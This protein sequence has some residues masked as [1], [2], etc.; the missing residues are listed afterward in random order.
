[1]C[2][3]LLS[4]LVFLCLQSAVFQLKVTDRALNRLRWSDDGRCVVVGDASGTV[5]V[6]KVAAEVGVCMCSFGS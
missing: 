1:M 4:A 5:H 2:F 3:R 6:L